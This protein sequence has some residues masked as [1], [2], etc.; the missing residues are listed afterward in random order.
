M[1][2]TQ[3]DARDGS[4]PTTAVMEIDQPEREIGEA[5]KGTDPRQSRKYVRDPTQVGP[6]IMRLPPGIDE[7]SGATEEG[8][9]IALAVSTATGRHNKDSKRQLRRA[10]STTNDEEDESTE[11]SSSSDDEPTER[12][13]KRLR[14]KLKQQTTMANILAKGI[15]ASV[16]RIKDMNAENK[17][18]T[19]VAENLSAR[20][21]RA[22]S[23][24]VD[25]ACGPSTPM[26]SD[27]TWIEPAGETGTQE[28]GRWT[29]DVREIA[30]QTEMG[31][32]STLRYAQKLSGER[33]AMNPKL[34]DNW[35]GRGVERV[36]YFLMRPSQKK[37][38]N[39]RCARIGREI[40][41]DVE[42]QTTRQSQANELGT[43]AQTNEQLQDTRSDS[44]DSG[45]GQSR[46]S[47]R[48]KNREEKR[49]AKEQVR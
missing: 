12:N 15:N 34:G 36:Y 44:I 8:R 18:L 3:R 13:V 41:A 20:I 21:R 14:K 24:G 47:R 29:T 42:R 23:A 40:D 17:K 5:D 46:T 48:Q 39:K 35:Q 31:A 7:N 27:L 10:P 37:V 25:V 32:S 1:P 2:T 6:L 11:L 38:W 33:A 19:E 30:V 43:T 45:L 16:D 49:Q 22:N 9:E 28:E 4:R 26:R